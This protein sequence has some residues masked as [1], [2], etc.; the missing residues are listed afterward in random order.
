MH[1]PGGAAAC[2]RVGGK[3]RAT[4]DVT[5]LKKFAPPEDATAMRKMLAVMITEMRDG[6]IEP[7][8]ASGIG[9]VAGIFLKS[10]ECEAI[11]EL[12]ERLAKLEG[13]AEATHDV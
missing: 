2:G 3:R 5:Q 11:T 10:V 6:K 8:L 12:R 13:K 1:L 7:K 4:Y 9:Y